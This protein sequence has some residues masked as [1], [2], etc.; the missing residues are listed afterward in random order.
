MTLRL[1]VEVL[2]LGYRVYNLMYWC[3]YLS[4]GNSETHL[5]LPQKRNV[6]NKWNTHSYLIRSFHKR[7][8]LNTVWCSILITEEH[9]MNNNIY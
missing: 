6:K 2:T 9:H 7:K 3:L 4:F 8:V 1:S 5:K